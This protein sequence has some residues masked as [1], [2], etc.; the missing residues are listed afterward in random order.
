MTVFQLNG[1]CFEKLKKLF[2]AGAISWDEWAD[3]KSRVTSGD[4]NVI[5]NLLR[6]NI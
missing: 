6:Y 2:S 4:R 1:V 3:L 5:T